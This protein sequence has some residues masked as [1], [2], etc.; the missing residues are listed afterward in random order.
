MEES[1]GLA[2]ELVTACARMI[3]WTPAGDLPISLAAARL[4]ARVVENGPTRVG[5]LAE[6]EHSSQPTITNHI[7]RLESLGLLSRAPDPTDGRA[8]IIT[9]TEE[10]RAKLAMVRRMLAANIE[11][12]VAQLSDADRE[13]LRAGVVA[14]HRLMALRMSATAAGPADFGIGEHAVPAHGETSSLS[15]TDATVGS[16]RDR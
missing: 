2:E 4:I 5:D 6:Q 11:P 14:M 13:A 8:W 9:A 3:R 7:K 16:A 15:A 12:M 1:R 10:G